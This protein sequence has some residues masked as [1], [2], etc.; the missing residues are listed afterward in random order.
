MNKSQ[1]N[2]FVVQNITRLIT[3][4]IVVILFSAILIVQ[5][6]NIFFRYT[7]VYDPWMWVGEFSRYSF[8]WIVFLLWHLS[9]RKDSHFV[10]DIILTKVKGTSR[11]ALEY[12]NRLI[13]LFFAGVIIWGSI[14]YIPTT[15][16]YSTASFRWLP[17]GVVYVVIPVGI[18][19][20]FIENLFLIAAK[21]GQGQK[22]ERQ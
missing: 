14:Q 21:M 4:I 10:V 6:L 3:E 16:L 15:M 9:D 13:T 22:G 1:K 18:L 20:V 11:L 12:F 7:K 19:L 8:I 2:A 5:V 17:M